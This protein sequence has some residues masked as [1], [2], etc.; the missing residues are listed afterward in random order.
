VLGR[1]RAAG[2]AGAGG[3][4]AALGSAGPALAYAAQERWAFPVN[5]PLEAKPPE[6]ALTF[7]AQGFGAW[8]RIDSDGNAVETRRDLAGVVTGFDRRFGDRT[9]GL[10]AGYSRSDISG[11]VGLVADHAQDHAV[12]GNFRVEF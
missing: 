8:G 4:Q 12:K 1:L 7:W 10:A 9:A 6:P 2:Y 11:Y 3:D 5:V